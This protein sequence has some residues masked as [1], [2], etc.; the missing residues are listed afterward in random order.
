MNSFT[1]AIGRILISILFLVS[2]ATKVMDPHSADA[3]IV[4]VGLPAGLGLI[5][6]VCEIMGGLL[7]A[8]GAFRRLVATLLSLFIVFATVLFHKNF[9]DPMQLANA[10]KNLA[11]I[12]GLVMGLAEEHVW[13]R[14]TRVVTDRRI[15]RE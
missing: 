12:G 1:A 15:H 2:G 11:I 7:L 13:S 9:A 14:T 10:L 3:M 5:T 4:G 8:I 6:G